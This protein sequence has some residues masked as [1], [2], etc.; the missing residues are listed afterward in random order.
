MKYI[1]AGFPLGKHLDSITLSKGNP[2]VTITTGIVG[3]IHTDE[4]GQITMCRLAARS[5]RNSGGP[6]IE[7]KTGK[8]LGVAVA[9]LAVAGIDSVG[10]IVTADELRHA[11][12]GRVGAISLDLKAISAAS[13]DLEIE[14]QLMILIALIQGRRASFRAGVRR[15]GSPQ[16]T[17]RG[18][19]FLTA[20]R[21][22]L[23]ARPAN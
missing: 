15:L 8:L 22:E 17:A 6:L 11:L 18:R 2:R 9:S 1:G 4:Y 21:S 12:A 13:A 23:Q 10:F 7:E 5:S 16:A 3:R 19:R 20:H 14:A